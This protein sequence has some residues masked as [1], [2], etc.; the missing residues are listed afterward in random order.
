MGTQSRKY[1][2]LRVQKSPNPHREHSYKQRKVLTYVVVAE[3]PNVANFSLLKIRDL[4][5]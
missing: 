3:S 4:L 5:D 2:G 1:I